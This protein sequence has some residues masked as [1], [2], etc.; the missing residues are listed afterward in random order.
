M[1]LNQR[2]KFKEKRHSK[3]KNTQKSILPC[4]NDSNDEIFDQILVKW[5]MIFNE[6]YQRIFSEYSMNI[7]LN[8]Y[9]MNIR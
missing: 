1:K 2:M 5:N 8:V 6:Y 7:P 3:K 4:E 9:T